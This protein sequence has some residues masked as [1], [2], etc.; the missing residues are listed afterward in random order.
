M[1]RRA[2]KVKTLNYVLDFL[3][4][5]VPILELTELIAIIPIEYLP[6]YMLSAVIARRAIRMLED[7][8]NVKRTED[9]P[10]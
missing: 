10:E 7:H 5:V 3:M 4:M 6:Y 8:L 1:T 9:T 2:K